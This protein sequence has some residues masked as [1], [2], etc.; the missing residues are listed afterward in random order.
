MTVGELLAAFQRP[1]DG[2]SGSRPA[3]FTEGIAGHF[4]P[5]DRLIA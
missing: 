4:L 5:L 3:R 1:N 2:S